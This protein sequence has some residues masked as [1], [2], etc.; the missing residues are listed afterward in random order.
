MALIGN[1]TVL[2]K[3]PIR[4]M[5]GTA[6]TVQTQLTSNYQQSGVV[7]SRFLQAGE[8]TMITMNAVP[9][10]TYPPYSFILPQKAGGIG[11]TGHRLQGTSDM[12]N[13]N[14]AA[15]WGMEVN[16][17]GA[18]GISYADMAAGAVLFQGVGSITGQLVGA[19]Q[20]SANLSGT[21]AMSAPLGALG[22]MAGVLAGTGAI[23]AG[24]TGGGVITAD[25]TSS[26]I[27]A[28]A[29]QV[30]EQMMDALNA[31]TIPVDTVKIHGQTIAGSGVTADP[32]RPE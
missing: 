8:T 17:L 12:N 30:V 14:L 1:Y 21:G 4:F 23:H 3:I 32:W 19:L 15:G 28:L 31:T 10:H 13:P 16:M 6:A 2:H 26:N 29:G 24:I 9:S 7:R 22:G 11:S 20:L 5:A 18:G 25:I 27:T